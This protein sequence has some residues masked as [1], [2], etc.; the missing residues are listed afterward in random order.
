[1][2]VQKRNADK[3]EFDLIKVAKAIYKARVDAG[4]DRYLEDCV[5]EAEEI[6][7]SLPEDIE[8]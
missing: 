1:M 3:Q 8:I 5:A 7:K 6:V 4:Q 2:F